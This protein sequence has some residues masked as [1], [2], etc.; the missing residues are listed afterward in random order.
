MIEGK[1]IKLREYSKD[2]YEHMKEMLN[3]R[4][5]RELMSDTIIYPYRLNEH[6]KYIETFSGNS[7]GIFKF[8]IELKESKS[9]IGSCG[10]DEM[11][12]K[13]RVGEIGISIK[14]ELW[15]KGY[16]TE[17][18]KLLIDFCFEEVNLNKIK[19]HVFDFN[20]RGIGSYKKLG[21]V[22]EGCLREEVYRFGKYNDVLVMGL[23]KS[24]W[25]NN[26]K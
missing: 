16:G 6:E 20:K 24:E 26:K 21:F 5:L 7:E 9:Y 4:E 11:D 3:D 12:Q 15:G 10:I 8:A 13:N 2:D 23:L 1:T 25:L 14:K 18:F 19:L 22:Q 17:A